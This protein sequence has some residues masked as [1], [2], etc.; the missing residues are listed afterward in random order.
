M[1]AT[2]YNPNYS[3]LLTQITFVDSDGI[4]FNLGLQTTPFNFE[5]DNVF[6]TYYLYYSQWE[7][8]C[9]FTLTL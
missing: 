5:S 8:T 4:T 2:I 7:I 6:G 3:N 9:E 1:T